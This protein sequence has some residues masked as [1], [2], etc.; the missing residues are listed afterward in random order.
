MDSSAEGC[1]RLSVKMRLERKL[2]Y[3][4]SLLICRYAHRRGVNR[5]YC[6]REQRQNYGRPAQWKYVEQL[7]SYIRAKHGTAVSVIGNGDISD[8]KSL[9]EKENGRCRRFMIGRSA[10]QKP[11]LFAEL[12]NSLSFTADLY[13]LFVF[14]MPSM[15]F[16]RRVPRK[17]GCDG[18]SILLQ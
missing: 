12:E 6:I 11:W 8:R 4:R 2:Y 3:G 1:K 7:A 9:E 18:F 15:S 14:L 5:S 16:S 13:E 17:Q 10:V